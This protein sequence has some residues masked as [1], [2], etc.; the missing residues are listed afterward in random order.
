MPRF[1]DRAFSFWS[2]SNTG[3]HVAI[4]QNGVQAFIDIF[5]R[6]VTTRPLL[7]AML[8]E[9]EDRRIELTERQAGILEFLHRQRRVMIAG[10]AVT[11][12][13]FIASEKAVRLAGEGMRVLLLCYNRGLAD[14][15]REQCPEIE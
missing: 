14:H 12:K 9:E 11:G 5:P 7:S 2:A 13:T 3:K 10:G 15:L 4:G 6:T 8:R 1:V